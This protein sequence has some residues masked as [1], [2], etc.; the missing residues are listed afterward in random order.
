MLLLITLYFSTNTCSS[1]LRRSQDWQ[2]KCGRFERRGLE[3]DGGDL[4]E[5][6]GN[7]EE[8][9]GDGEPTEPTAT[10]DIQRPPGLR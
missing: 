3:E 2:E 1:V 10:S 4:E 7:L 5:G 9:E 8:G 6:G